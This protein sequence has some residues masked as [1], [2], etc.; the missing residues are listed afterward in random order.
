MHAFV[1]QAILIVSAQC[2]PGRDDVDGFQVSI[3]DL[4]ESGVTAGLNL[5]RD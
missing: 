3:V 2:R 1:K 5:L 4:A